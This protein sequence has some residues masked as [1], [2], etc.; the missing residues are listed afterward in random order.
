MRA[1]TAAGERPSPTA[2]V[3]AAIRALYAALPE[4]LCLAPDPEAAALL[5]RPLDWPAR[6]VRQLPWAG[7]A[8]HFGLGVVSLGGTCHVALRTR[9]ID[10]ALREAVARGVG[11]VVLLGAGL[12]NRARRLPELQEATVFEVDHPTVQSHKRERL[13]AV[14]PGRSAASPRLVLV[15]VDFERERLDD[16][17]TRAGFSPAER[18]FWIWEGVTPYLTPSAIQSTLASLAVLASSGSRLAVTYHRPGSMGWLE[19]VG[20]IVARRLGE[21]LWG[22]L[23]PERIREYLDRAGFATLSDESAVDW[24]RRY[25]SRT[26]PGLWEWERLVLAERCADPRARATVGRARGPLA[27]EN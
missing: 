15:P 16:A 25:W 22:M 8:I 13:A 14:G 19:R 17:L 9:A 4:P 11:Q 21:P 3:V 10:D 20:A 26:P 6:L 5:S 23:E 27:P 24:A 12:D 1:G 18:S 7:E 2:S